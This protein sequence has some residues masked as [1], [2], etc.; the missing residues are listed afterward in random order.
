MNRRYRKFFAE[1]SPRPDCADCVR[2][3]LGQ[4]AALIQESIQGYPDHIWLAIGHIAEAE[5]ESQGR[6]PDFAERLREER[7][8]LE[9]EDGY[10][11]DMVALIHEVTKRVIKESTR[12]ARERI[13][14]KWGHTLW[15]SG[16]GKVIDMKGDSMHYNWIA[17]NFSKLFPDEEFSDEAVFEVP[18][19]HG[20]IHVRNRAGWTS[21][22][23]PLIS[24][25]G[26]KRAV[27]RRGGILQDIIIDGMDLAD[28]G[29]LM[30]DISYNDRHRDS[31][32]LPEDMGALLRA[33]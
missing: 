7:K 32:D 15:I 16:D 23:M 26:S 14:K 28:S 12:E 33:L 8:K 30:V 1:E 25:T 18:H 9:S 13:A 5:A 4:A 20:W 10:S 6:W 22:K 2:K 21:G 19:R 17:K 3:H 11:P 24:I 31:Y 29:K 27:K